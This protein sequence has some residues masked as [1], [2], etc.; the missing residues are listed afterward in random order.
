MAILSQI[1][2]K[3]LLLFLI[4][5]TFNLRLVLSSVGLKNITF[6]SLEGGLG[7]LPRNF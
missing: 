1:I 4:N 7:V 2:R 5:F 3:L 6:P